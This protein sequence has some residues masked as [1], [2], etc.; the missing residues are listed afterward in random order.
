V[1]VKNGACAPR[2]DHHGGEVLERGENEATR[3]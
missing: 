1:F 3:C 2:N